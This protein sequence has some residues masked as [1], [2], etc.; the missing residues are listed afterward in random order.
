MLIREGD[1]CKYKILPVQTFF[2]IT[3]V[4]LFGPTLV[5]SYK[6]RH[7]VKRETCRF[8]L[9]SIRLILLLTE[10]EFC[11]NQKV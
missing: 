4:S 7:V 10:I 5:L 1:F 2:L 11:T 9:E 8:F 3:F 6:M